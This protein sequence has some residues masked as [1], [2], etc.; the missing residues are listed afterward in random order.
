[1]VI[2]VRIEAGLRDRL[3]EIAAEAESER[4]MLESRL[5]EI[6]RRIDELAART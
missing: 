3:R 1:M 5:H 6:A 2:Q 4:A